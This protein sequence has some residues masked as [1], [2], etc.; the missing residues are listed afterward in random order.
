MPKLTGGAS[1]QSA[2]RAGCAAV[3]RL[4]TEDQAGTAGHMISWLLIERP[5]P[6]PADA[7]EATLAGIIAP[8]RVK[9]LRAAGLRIL[10]IRRPGRHPRAEQTGCTVFV[11][12]GRPGNHWLEQLDLRDR[13]TLAEID[14]EAVAAGQGGHGVLVTSPL[15]LVCTHGAKD[16]CCA[17]LGRPLVA[18]L[19]QDHPEGVWE[20]S[21]V[22]GDRWAGNLL[23]VPDGYLYGQLEPAKAALVAKAAMAGQVHPD[24]LRGRT[25][26]AST[27]EQVAEVALRRHT[28][29]TDIDDVL[30]TAVQVHGPDTRTVL[31][32]AGDQHYEVVVRRQDTPISSHSRCAGTRH[33]LV[34]YPVIDI[35]PVD[36]SR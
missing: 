1:G 15:L 20:V 9:A 27:W 13:S 28:G 36:T 34:T 8:E 11:G 6:W 18:G 25:S 26:A 22:G 33:A 29:L 5:G 14:L 30:A 32:A 3:A 21:H 31:V 24:Y 19:A 10:L 23:V 4:L 2:N 17:V 12:S 7:V 35:R 16:M